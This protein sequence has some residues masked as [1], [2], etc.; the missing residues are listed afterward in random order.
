VTNNWYIAR[1]KL[2]WL[3][4]TSDQKKGS[5]TGP[6]EAPFLLA[7]DGPGNGEGTVAGL[8]HPLAILVLYPDARDRA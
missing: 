4:S 1:K 8:R 3:R 5:L 2:T 7:A 6:R